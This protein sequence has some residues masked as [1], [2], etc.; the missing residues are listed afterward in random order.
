MGAG[1]RAMVQLC[2]HPEQNIHRSPNRSHTKKGFSEPHFGHRGGMDNGLSAN[3]HE[4]RVRQQSTGHPPGSRP[5][6]QYGGCA[7]QAGDRL[8]RALPRHGLADR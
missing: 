8:A 3:S 6:R 5:G 1:R 4:R 2:S 7:D